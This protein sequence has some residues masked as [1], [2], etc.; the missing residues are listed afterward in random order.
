[1]LN[2]FEHEREILKSLREG[3]IPSE[4][5]REYWSNEEKDELRRCFMDGDGISQIA[6]ALQRSE[7]AIVQQLISTGLLI[8]TGTAGSRSGKDRKCRCPRCKESGCTCNEGGVCR[9]AG[10]L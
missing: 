1:M 5:S 2:R 3:K 9:Y 6:I 7:N 10:E 8:P 4:R